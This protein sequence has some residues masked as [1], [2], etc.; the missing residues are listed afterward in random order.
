MMILPETPSHH[1]VPQT[2][3]A[4]AGLL[5]G[6]N[7]FAWTPDYAQLSPT[8]RA[9][10]H[11]AQLLEDDSDAS[12][13]S[14]QLSFSSW[15]RA[16]ALGTTSAGR[17]SFE[18]ESPQQLQGPAAQQQ[19]RPSKRSRCNSLGLAQLPP[20]SSTYRQHYVPCLVLS[21]LDSSDSEMETEPAAEAG[22]GGGLFPAPSFNPAT[23]KLPRQLPAGAHHRA[24]NAAGGGQPAAVVSSDFLLG[25]RPVRTCKRPRSACSQ[26]SS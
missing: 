10:T 2:P 13:E 18:E 21:P 3:R 22:A 6:R 17:R 9:Q 8:P 26:S 23:P 4:G 14:S 16:T 1:L 15:H 11:P 20:P 19:G 25:M 5:P 24:R 12:A 7:V